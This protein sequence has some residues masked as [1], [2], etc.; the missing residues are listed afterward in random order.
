[1]HPELIGKENLLIRAKS[2]YASDYAL[3]CDSGYES[4]DRASWNV[5]GSGLCGTSCA[6]PNTDEKPEDRR[7]LC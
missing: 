3:V 5:V 4:R 6:I 1:M 2:P 7:L